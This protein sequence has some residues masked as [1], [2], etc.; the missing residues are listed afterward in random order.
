MGRGIKSLYYLIGVLTITL[1]LIIL[2]NKRI[3]LFTGTSLK[4]E[5]CPEGFNKV[6]TATQLEIC[7][8]GDVQNNTCVSGDKCILSSK[9]T[10][11][12]IPCVTLLNRL[13]KEKA[14]RVCPRSMKTYFYNPKFG[15]ACTSEPLNSALN[16]L[17]DPTKKGNMC[18]T[19][20]EK[21]QFKNADSC[22]NKKLL[23][24]LYCIDST[25]TKSIRRFPTNQ[26][27]DVYGPSI[28]YRDNSGNIKIAYPKQWVRDYYT[29]LRPDEA[30]SMEFF[31]FLMNDNIII[32]NV[33]F[34]LALERQNA[35]RNS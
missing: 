15:G 32:E 11:G 23:E 29:A 24:S 35:A 22:Y 1:I 5:E 25:C 33:E 34:A 4:L 7:C 20:G 17:A 19:Y 2:K 8:K 9:T 6:T 28:T 26:S 21:D 14:K 27:E 18:L 30:N 3:E 10:D 12:M 31:R 16:N 13:N